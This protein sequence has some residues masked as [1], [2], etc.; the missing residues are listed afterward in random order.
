MSLVA[1]FLIHVLY[2]LDSKLWVLRWH[3]LL[4]VAVVCLLR[5]LQIVDGV[6]MMGCVAFLVTVVYC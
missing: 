1:S 3:F 4:L 2:G 5:L 6:L